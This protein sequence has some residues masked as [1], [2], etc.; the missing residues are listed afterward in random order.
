[1]P[2][3]CAGCNGLGF[4]TGEALDLALGANA[5]SFLGGSA[6]GC[7]GSGGG[8]GRTP[9]LRWDG[10][11]E[12]AASPTGN[13]GNLI[14]PVGTV[15]AGVPTLV[16]TDIFNRFFKAGTKGASIA[17]ALGMWIVTFGGDSSAPRNT[18]SASFIRH[19]R[20]S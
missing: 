16:G 1:M 4:L 6:F 3:A 9:V 19:N 2:F 13:A 14:F 15:A 18:S 12:G 17:G 5:T 20:V 7:E 10:V 8:G 11:G